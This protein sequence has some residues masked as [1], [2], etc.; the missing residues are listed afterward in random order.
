MPKIVE[1]ALV[2]YP[3]GS[4]YPKGRKG[5]Y[6]VVFVHVNQIGEEQV[7]REESPP[8]MGGVTNNRMELEA[9]VKGLKLA[10]EVACFTMVSKIV[11]RTDSQYIA[12]HYKFALGAWRKQRWCNSDG[13]PV[14]HAD[15]WKEFVSV[16]G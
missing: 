13:R 15:L 7:V 12:R 16:Y 3:D 8:G 6:G 14:E 5:G 4:L 11:V 2:I 9:C 10:P 1:N